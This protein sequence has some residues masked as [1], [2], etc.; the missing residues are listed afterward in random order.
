MASHRGT[1]P[2][3]NNLTAIVP[4][5]AKHM[6]YRN[7]EIATVLGVH[8]DT[9]RDVLSGRTWSFARTTPVDWERLAVYWEPYSAA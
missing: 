7:K 1:S 4:V 5:V 8:P 2:G 9:V 6:G 3:S